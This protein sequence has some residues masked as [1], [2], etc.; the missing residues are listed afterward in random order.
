MPLTTDFNVSPYFDDYDPANNYYRI[1][2]RPAVA[3]QARE[4][5]QSQS[6]LQAQIE[7]FGDHIFKDGAVVSGCDHPVRIPNFD[8][9]RVADF[10]TANANAFVSDITSD[11]LLVGQT[12]N[13]RAVAVVTKT[14][15]LLNYPDTNRLYLKYVHNGSNNEYVFTSGETIAIYAN[16]EI[17]G[18]T[19]LDSNNLINTIS[20]LTTNATVNATGK[21]FGLSLDAG[22]IYQKGFMQNTAPQTITVR[23]YDQNVADYVVG[24]T[25]LEEIITENTDASLLDNALGYSNENAPGAHRVKLTPTLVAKPRTEI[26]N[27]DTFFS[28]F[29]FSNVTNEIA[30]NKQKTPYDMLADVMNQRT[31]DESGNYVVKPFLTETIEGPNT[32]SFS[33]QVSS[34]KGFV[35]GSEIE[36]LAA[37]KVDVDKATTTSTANQQIITANYG[38]YVNVKEYAGALNY[39][40]LVTVDLYDNTGFQAITNKYTPSFTGKTKIGSAQ[41]KSVLHDTGDPG[42]ANTTYRIYM[43]N[44]VMNSGKSFSNDVKSIYAN[45]SVNT[46]GAF[47]ADMVL[48]TNSR[49]V[50]QQSGKSSLVFPFGKKA[51]KTLRSANGTYNGTEFYFRSSETGTVLT[52]G[53]INISNG[54]S[55][56][57]GVDTIGY[58]TGVLGDTLENQFI[59]VF[60]ANASTANIN[61]NTVSITSGCTY[62]TGVNLNTYFAPGEFIR[63][64]ETS[65]NNY[66]QVASAN[67]TRLV[68]TT[69]PSVT[70]AACVIG[71][72]FPA[73]YTVPL[74]YGYPGT[75]SVDVTSSTTLTVNTGIAA[76]AN[77][78]SNASC[79]IQYRKIR[80]TATQAKKD[81]KKDRFIKLYA[82]AASNNSWNLG[83][84]DVYNIKHVYA[85]NSAYANNDS[86]EIT[87]Y[88]ILDTGQRDDFYDHAKLVLKPQYAGVLTNQ[89]L[90]VVVDHFTANLNSGIGFFSVDSYPID[91]ANTANT[92]AITTAQIPLYYTGN[93]AIDLRDAV[94][95]R[96]FKANTANSST[97]L[98]GATAN[99]TTT[100]TFITTT[101]YLVEP[102]TNFQSDIEYYLGRID[103]IT[104][105][106]TGG[107][108]VTQ[109]TPSETPKSPVSDSDVMVISTA[110]VPPYPSL[111]VR[112][113]ENYNRLDYAVRTKIATNRGYTMKDIGLFD[114]R[115]KRLEY[116]TT[117]NMLEQKAQN[118]QIS[119]ANGLNRFKNGIFADP[120]NS[121]ALA[122]ASDIEYRYSIDTIGGYGRPLFSSEN[123]D[124]A[125]SNS[126]SS[127]VTV[128]GSSI[129]RPYT[130]EMYISQ[131]FATKI[132]NNSQDAW[133]W[134][135]SVELFPEYDMNRDETR[136]PNIDASIDLTLPFVQF[137]SVVSQA[138][139]ATIFGT[140]YGDW[141]TISD[142]WS[143][144]GNWLTL[145]SAQQRT[146]TNTFIV[147]ITNSQ[148]LGKFVSDISVQ[149][150]MKSRVIS[151]VAKNL[152]PNCKIYAFFDD[153]PVSQ[154][155][156]PAVWNHLGESASTFQLDVSIAAASGHPEDICF[157]T[158]P[159]GTQLVTDANGNLFGQFRIPAGTFRI[160]DRQLQLVDVD[161]LITGYDAYMTRAA[162]TFT[163]SNISI[164]TRNTTLSVT[165]P[166]IRQSSFIDSR[167][168]TQSW[169]AGEPIAQSLAI[170]APE[171]QS[172]VFVT[173]IDL[174]FKQKD[175]NLGI[176]V[177]F[178][179]MNNGV[180]DTSK[181]L[182]KG[183]L[184]ANDILLSD[185]ATVASTF[186]MNDPIFVNDKTEYAFYIQ[187]DGNSP[188][189]QMWMS[190]IGYKDI[191]TGSQVYQ[192]PYCGDAFRSSNSKTW[193][194]L[195]KEDIKFNLYVANFST[196]TGTAYFTNENDDYITY[197]S[198]AIA[199]SQVTVNVGD[200]VYLINSAS[201]V[202]ITNTAVTAR[203]QFIDTTTAKMVLDSSTGGFS[204]NAKI[205]IFRT[206]QYANTTQA[207]STT[208]IAT[209]VITTVTDPI[210]NAIVPRFATMQ[211][212]GSTI[213]VA[214]T[215]TSNSAV[216]DGSYYDL[217]MEQEREMLDYERRIYSRSNDNAIKSLKLKTQ[218]T[219]SNKYLS[220]VIS[221]SRKSALII[222]NIVN[223]DNTNE[224]T[225][226]GNAL[227]K[228]IS[229]PIVLADGQEAED[230]KIY[231]SAY[232][233][234]NTDVEVY[235]KFLNN[236]DPAK[237]DD[238]VW[239]K[240]TNN[241]SDV[242][243]SPLNYVDF[244]EY[245]YSLPA[246]A[247]VTYAAYANPSNYNILRYSDVNGAVYNTYKTFAIKI[248]LLSTDGTYVPKVD[249]LRGIALQV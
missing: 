51:L 145:T 210:L 87:Q 217:S 158:S 243:C 15:A 43:T 127:G 89:Y 223:N 97:T 125:Y 174:F 213:S 96:G 239:T 107:L 144:S 137:G 60:T 181:V 212:L 167:V 90:T 20:V 92:N 122:N 68:L 214:F 7:R 238:K 24:F 220:P 146:V 161:S 149:P 235:V 209:A 37:R 52:N 130:H 49:A 4:L 18:N 31:Y 172:G 111:S 83:L 177:V 164:S 74:Q 81:V 113:A 160:G 14:G 84:P 226:Y 234:I 115:I 208:L 69:A 36:Y 205:G 191:T 200:E 124:L 73:G 114:D 211:P 63:I 67:T 21:G 126:L 62:V 19:V 71:K 99:P 57:G 93:T 102:D 186:V 229:Q 136:L 178:V 104:M 39:G 199:N 54:S 175:P 77:L 198:L 155:C 203:V 248:V 221:L 5:T 80:T 53:L 38:N 132:R 225:R 148:D 98:A 55:Y 227:A 156:A 173:K 29:E 34:G 121:H 78:T 232:R 204:N 201:N 22:V 40:A 197:N 118:V 35:L 117:L 151:F 45:S 23:D 157:R 195:P 61:G 180:P 134:K 47:Y 246:S 27:N 183:R 9:V 216:A 94:D 159:W 11:Y 143:A 56:T 13:V 50:L 176:E 218:L 12:S 8:Y 163:A 206:P 222:K 106:K 59:V 2:F 219:A 105:N 129:T 230:L 66:Y 141:R 184:E 202:A 139:G 165:Q 46:F 33:Y 48:D 240:M 153:T 41:V 91:D 25:T 189:Y 120:M 207:N 237:L 76:V 135:G 110:R 231:V 42:L 75:R 100:N 249:D 228:Y 88:F 116:Y 152:K 187:A 119:D 150:Y 16:T 192:N 245:T 112:E 185:D 103:L 162:A 85:N 140:R 194:S 244:K 196:G 182:G 44:I 58:S 190:E 123:I 233:P 168:I 241:S 6:I 79:V 142:S 82:N 242:Y 72:H 169:W 32:S 128:T 26:S 179:A 154:H 166:S 247:P 133:S 3:V 109:G 86:D 17:T 64:T 1:L 236:E 95:F 224:H 70:N 171:Q 28:V 30:I 188:G 131:P 65:T 101:A 193:T 138:T 147:P 10:F 108:S 215:G 170:N